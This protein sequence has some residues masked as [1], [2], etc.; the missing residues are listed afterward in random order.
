MALLNP[1][2][3]ILYALLALVLIAVSTLS[4]LL[5]GTVLGSWLALWGTLVVRNLLGRKQSP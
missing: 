5:L 4:G 2:F 3:T 1:G